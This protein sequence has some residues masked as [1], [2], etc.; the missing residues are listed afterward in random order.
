MVLITTQLLSPNFS[1]STISH[2]KHDQSKPSLLHQSSQLTQPLLFLPYPLD[3]IDE[4]NY[5]HFIYIIGIIGNQWKT[6]TQLQEQWSTTSLSM[7]SNNMITTTPA[8]SCSNN[9]NLVASALLSAGAP[10]SKGVCRLN[11]PKVPSCRRLADELPV[12]QSTDNQN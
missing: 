3:K 5:L 7:D 4:I 8:T 11:C 12:L 1:S 9:L 2:M 10:M 6:Q